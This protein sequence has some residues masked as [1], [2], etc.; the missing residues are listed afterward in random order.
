M[1][2]VAIA[3]QSAFVVVILL[4][5]AH[6]VGAGA[7][8]LIADMAALAGHRIVQPHQREGGEV[9]IELIDPF[10]AIGDVTGGAHLHI[11]IFVDVVRSV[12]GGA[13]PRQ[14]ILQSADVAVGTSQG[15]VVAG[16]REARH[17]GV[18]KLRLFPTHGAMASLTLLAVA[19][20]VDVAVGV[21][22]VAGRGQVFL[23]YAI[24][25]TGAAGQLRVMVAQRK[26]GGVVI[27]NA[28]LPTVDRVAGV[29]L[30]AVFASVNIGGFVA[31]DAG[32]F[33]KLIT[34]TG[35]TT[36]ARHLSVFAAQIEAGGGVVELLAFLPA[37]G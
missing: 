1:A 24:G 36:A 15:L 25:V 2:S 4:M 23:D 34:L 21:T 28:L 8:K 35:V 7:G 5:A 26:I 17:F 31:A 3:A 14:I 19:T 33:L 6:A 30:F 20:Q 10:P 9:V 18:L 37:L 16:E 22:T 27:E 11:R 32:G 29:T 12:A 13:I